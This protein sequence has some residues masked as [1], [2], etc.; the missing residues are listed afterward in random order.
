MFLQK[1]VSITHLRAQG[2]IFHNKRKINEVN[3]T[4]RSIQICLSYKIFIEAPDIVVPSLNEIQNLLA[5][6]KCI[7]TIETS[8]QCHGLLLKLEYAQSGYRLEQVSDCLETSLSSCLKSSTEICSIH[9]NYE[10]MYLCIE[11]IWNQISNM[12]IKN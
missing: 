7:V 6:T 5:T 11:K 1:K 10:R 2:S 3:G 9:M 12:M 8:H 4:Q